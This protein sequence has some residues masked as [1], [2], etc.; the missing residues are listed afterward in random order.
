M[1]D[2]CDMQPDS[3]SGPPHHTALAPNYAAAISRSLCP[4]LPPRDP[5]QSSTQDQYDMCSNRGLSCS[6]CLSL[7]TF[8]STSH[9]T[10]SDNVYR[11][12]CRHHATAVCS[13]ISS[14]FSISFICLHLDLF[15]ITDTSEVAITRRSLHLFKTTVWLVEEASFQIKEFEVSHHFSLFFTHKCAL[16]SWRL[17]GL[18][19]T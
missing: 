12:K 19:F 17:V 5:L 11:H 3:P 15:P 7:F 6:H 10:L 4:F 13:Q 1:N 16:P 14:P 9:L 2:R 18:L 8:L